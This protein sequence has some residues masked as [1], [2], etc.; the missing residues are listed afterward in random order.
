MKEAPSLRSSVALILALSLSMAAWGPA[1][2]AV[3]SEAAAAGTEASMSGR[4]FGQD[5]MPIEDARIRV[6][7]LETGEELASEPA[8]SSGAYRLG[9]LA[10]GRYEVAVETAK[11]VYLV[12]RSMELGG[13]DRK[14]YSFKL[15]DTSPD[16]ARAMAPSWAKKEKK[17][18][19]PADPSK[20]GQPTFWSNPLTVTL[21]GLAIVTVLYIGADEARGDSERDKD[22]SPSGP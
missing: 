3:E 2:S 16:E 21:A 14:S 19:D 12:D 20:K 9:G 13:A 4:V 6:H 22:L 15:K 7:S 10:A 11:G 18:D 5:G 1:L 17:E 8:D